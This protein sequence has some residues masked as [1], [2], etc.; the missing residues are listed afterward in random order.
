MSAK[1]KIIVVDDSETNL[2]LLEAILEDEG[3]IVKTAFSVKEATELL[4]DYKPNLILLDLLMPN[5]NGFDLLK[6][7]KLN[8]SYKDIPVII[9]TAFAN[10]ENSAIAFDLGAFDIIEK[11]I[12]IPF[13]LEKVNKALAIF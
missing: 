7:L 12:D 5:E 3:F 13:F 11:P 1:K 8:S 9:V 10:R 4:K 2:V 6:K